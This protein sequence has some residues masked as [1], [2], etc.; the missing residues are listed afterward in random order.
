M[1]KKHKYS[2][3]EMSEIRCGNPDCRKLLKKNVV[4][5]K[6]EGTL[7]LCWEC[8]VKKTRNMTLSVYKKYRAIRAKIRLES[9]DPRAA[10]T[11]A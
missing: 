2:F 11:G 1:P 9:G 6:P 3:T 8:S 4:E 5:R 7:I 10:R